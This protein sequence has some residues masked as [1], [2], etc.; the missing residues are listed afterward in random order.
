MGKGGKV[1]AWGY[2]VV[3][4]IGRVFG[5]QLHCVY[6]TFSSLKK[7]RKVSKFESFSFLRFSLLSFLFSFSK[8]SF[9][10]N[11]CIDCNI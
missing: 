6:F 3:R 2:G 10:E 1:T 9:G 7:E 5:F 11:H 4:G 8:F